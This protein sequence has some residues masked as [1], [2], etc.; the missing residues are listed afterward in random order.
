MQSQSLGKVLR[1]KLT[2]DFFEGMVV[3]GQVYREGVIKA[4][5]HCYYSAVT[6]TTTTLPQ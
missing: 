1:I 6:T 3:Q 2:F 5:R 4:A